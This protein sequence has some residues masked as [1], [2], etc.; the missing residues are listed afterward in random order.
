MCYLKSL[1]DI[2]KMDSSIPDEIIQHICYYLDITSLCHLRQTSYFFYHFIDWASLVDYARKNESIN[3]LLG[4][5]V[6]EMDLISQVY[7]HLEDKEKELLP[8]FFGVIGSKDGIRFCIYKQIF[9]SE[10]DMYASIYVRNIMHW[11]YETVFDVDFIKMERKTDQYKSRLCQTLNYLG[12]DPMAKIYIDISLHFWGHRLNRYHIPIKYWDTTNIKDILLSDASCDYKNDPTPLINALI[13]TEYKIKNGELAEKIVEI[14]EDNIS[15]TY[16]MIPYLAYVLIDE[17]PHLLKRLISKTDETLLFHYNELIDSYTYPSYYNPTIVD[18]VVTHLFNL[19]VDIWECYANI[20]TLASWPILKKYIMENKLSFSDF[21]I[22]IPNDY[23]LDE[24]M[25]A[26]KLGSQF[27]VTNPIDEDS[28][29][30]FKNVP[31]LDECN[32]DYISKIQWFYNHGCD[33]QNYNYQKDLQIAMK[34][35]NIELA[36]VLIKENA[37]DLDP[38]CLE[39]IHSYHHD[40]IDWY[41]AQDANDLDDP[42][43]LEII[44]GKIGTKCLDLIPGSSMDYILCDQHTGLELFKIIVRYISNRTDFDDIMTS[45]INHFETKISPSKKKIRSMINRDKFNW[46]GMFITDSMHSLSWVKKYFE[47]VVQLK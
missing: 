45:V 23:T 39:Y 7:P 24:L 9:I 29:D 27:D 34:E 22:K 16:A 2:M 21:K 46:L 13:L 12:I 17:Y 38:L 5:M 4:Q 40:A 25:E 31:V 10:T 47:L 32:L 15:D 36:N 6:K 18:I 28:M 33:M 26:E 1:I 30:K 11:E 42:K 20:I 3:H 43:I 35:N 41:I 44:I 8:L 19:P 37:D 14:F